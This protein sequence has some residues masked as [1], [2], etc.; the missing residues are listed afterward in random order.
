MKRLLFWLTC[1]ISVSAHAQT[2]FSS[3][4]L[5]RPSALGRYRVGVVNGAA[6]LVPRTGNT[7]RIGNSAAVL[8]VAGKTGTVTL[9]KTDVGLGNV[10]NLDATLR[11]NHTGTQSASTIS[12]LSTVATSGAYTDLTGKPTIPTLTSQLTNDAGFVSGSGAAA[13]APVQ[14]VAGRTGNV[15]L[16]KTDVGLSAVPNVDATA[17]ANHTGTQSAATITGLSTVA[18]TGAYADLSGRPTFATVATSGAYSDLTGRPGLATSSVDGLM[19]ATDKVRLYRWGLPKAIALTAAA[20]NSLITHSLGTDLGLSSPTI[21]VQFQQNG[22]T[23]WNVGYTYVDS[24]SIRIVTPYNA[25][26]SRESFTGT[27]LIF[28]IP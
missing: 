16:S 14:T 18:T 5:T 20:H 9:T 2:E 17:R 24:N 25:D 1:L 19:P 4:T 6:Y 8:S 21:W 10:A 11:A 28:V 23:D 22:I 27:V 13:A 7:I 15:T 26:G 12:G 3:D